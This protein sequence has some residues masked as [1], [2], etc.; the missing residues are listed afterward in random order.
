M[1]G[2]AL[3][4]ASC[5]RP[6]AA[7]GLWRG[8]AL[9]RT[10]GPCHALPQVRAAHGQL[11]ATVREVCFLPGGDGQAAKQQAGS[12]GG[13]KPGP[14]PGPGQAAAAGAAAAEPDKPRLGR[15]VNCG[16][17]LLRMLH[18][19]LQFCYLQQRWSSRGEQQQVGAGAGAAC[20]AMLWLHRLAGL[21]ALRRRCAAR[22]LTRA[23]PPLLHPPPLPRRPQA[24]TQA[25]RQALMRKLRLAWHHGQFRQG[26]QFACRQIN[27]L[28]T[29]GSQ[30]D[31]RTLL[32]KLDCNGW[33]SR[34]V[35]GRSGEELPGA[36]MLL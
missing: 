21:A 23:A 27:I 36:S 20:R 22:R 10:R 11:L 18:H 9:S 35:I 31:L 28:A 15:R 1:V 3:S 17:A 26:Y 19:A 6:A 13:S 8:P 29:K 5:A 30:Y 7:L 33:A 24:S 32:A 12:G 4:A 34:Q 2:A 14:A 16:K 25:A